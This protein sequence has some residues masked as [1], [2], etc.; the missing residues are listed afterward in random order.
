MKITKKMVQNYM[1]MLAYVCN[2]VMKCE[3][4]YEMRERLEELYEEMDEVGSTI[5]WNW[6]KHPMYVPDRVETAVLMAIEE[7]ELEED[8]EEDE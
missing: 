2:E 7:I 4:S 6:N 3:R 1:E 8:F 5:K